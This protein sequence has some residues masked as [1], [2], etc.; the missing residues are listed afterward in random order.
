MTLVIIAFVALNVFCCVGLIAHAARAQIG[1]RATR[2]LRFCFASA[3]AAIV[4]VASAARVPDALSRNGLA[5]MDDDSLEALVPRL[6]VAFCRVFVACSLAALAALA[7]AALVRRSLQRALALRRLT[8]ALS[9]GALAWTALLEIDRGGLHGRCSAAPPPPTNRRRRAIFSSTKPP[10]RNLL[11]NHRVNLLNA[12]TA[13]GSW[14]DAHLRANVRRTIAQFAGW[15]T[16]FDDDDACERRLATDPSLD[17]LSRDRLLFWYR[18]RGR[19]DPS[20]WLWPLALWRRARWW[21]ASGQLLSPTA[22]PPLFGVHR[23]AFRSD[24]C[25]LAQLYSEGGLYLDNDVVPL[26][27]LADAIA[28]PGAAPVTTVLEESQKYLFQ[29]ILAAPP[30]SDLVR[31][32]LLY[33]EEWVCGARAATGENVG[34]ALLMQAVDDEYGL[35]AATAAGR[36]RLRSR[37][38]VHILVEVYSAAKTA[39]AHRAR[40]TNATLRQISPRVWRDGC[41]VVVA[42]EGRRGGGDRSKFLELFS[43]R[44][45]VEPALAHSRSY[46]EERYTGVG[47]L[48][49]SPE[50]SPQPTRRRLA[51]NQCR[52]PKDGHFDASSRCGFSCSQRRSAIVLPR[53][54]E[55]GGLN[56]RIST[57]EAIGNLAHSLCAHLVAAEPCRLMMPQLTGGNA[58]KC[59]SS[60]Y[61]YLNL[62]YRQAPRDALPDE[63]PRWFAGRSKLKAAGFEVIATPNLRRNSTADAL[64]RVDHSAAVAAAAAGRP[65]VWYIALP[66]YRWVVPFRDAVQAP[67]LARGCPAPSVSQGSGC[68]FVDGRR[69]HSALAT[70][71]RDAYLRRHELKDYDAVHIRRFL[72]N[73]CND[74]RSVFVRRHVQGVLKDSTLPL[75]VSTNDRRPR[76]RKEL[77]DQLKP[78]RLIFPAVELAELARTRAKAACAPKAAPCRAHPT[79]N[80]I[81]FAAER[82][83]AAAAHVAFHVGYKPCGKVRMGWEGVWKPGQ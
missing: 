68:S 22:A 71:L 20:P 83:I 7:L 46:L 29:A 21:V 12:S 11:F 3:L 55:N 82:A 74:S 34:P 4:V 62:S 60:W 26:A 18:K 43:D 19:W 17:F 8:L 59:N 25:R 52:F 5:A 31:R 40:T 47:A 51:E 75:V 61:S 76:F 32:A 39:A 41:D 66:L 63:D 67:M 35:S 54:Y 27:G 81:V 57:F 42:A 72:P 80:Y 33:F 10:P 16:V 23:G 70:A 50:E 24:L 13:D 2:L 69:A 45:P 6:L 78:R 64:V 28:G 79:D 53:S 14:E 36:R 38:G 49:C 56:D 9:L 1:E 37:H 48:P 65:F 30:R 15:R 44:T 73:K 77:T 58:A